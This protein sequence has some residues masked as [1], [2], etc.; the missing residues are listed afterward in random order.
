[1]LDSAQSGQIEIGPQKG[2][3]TTFM[4]SPADIA[5]YGGAAGSGKTMSL[6]LEPIRHI[7]NKGFGA[8]IFRRKSVE[9]AQE[10]GLWDETGNLYPHINGRPR[11][12]PRFEWSFP[13]G[14]KVQ[15]SHLEYEK[16]IYDWQ[17]AQVVMFGFDELTHFC[18]SPDHEVLTQRGWIPI[19]DVMTGDQVFAKVGNSIQLR[20]VLDT[21]SFDYSGDMIE[22][23]QEHGISVKMTPNHRVLVKHETEKTLGFVNADR[24]EKVPQEIFCPS[25]W[26]TMG[27]SSER[28][29][30]VG[31]SD[32][33]KVSYDGKIHCLVVDC[34]L[35]RDF[36]NG[37]WAPGGNFLVRRN[38]RTHFT[39]N[40]ATQFWYMLSRNRSTCGIK[41]YVRATTNPDADSWV[42]ELIAWWINQD[43]GYPIQERSGVLRYFVR[44]GDT[45]IWGDTPEDLQGYKEPDGKPLPVKSL[46]FVSARLEDNEILMRLDPDY[47][48]N[49]MALSTVER[50][51]LL[52]GNWK[53]RPQ[54]GLYFKRQWVENKIMDQAPPM[55]KIVR[56]WDLAA[57]EER[58]GTD[59][60][61]TE[62][63]K[64]GVTY[65]GDFWIL[66]HVFDRLAPGGVEEM[67]LRTARKDGVR[68][69]IAIPQDPAQAGKSQAVNLSKKLAGFDCR[70]K[71]ASGDKITRF[72]PF[73]AQAENGNVYILR[74][75]WNERLIK[76]LENFPPATVGHDDTAD[77]VSEAFDAL[78]RDRNPVVVT[79]YAMH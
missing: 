68:T 60:D 47:R 14:A 25:D 19:A 13:S 1:M 50:E 61:W 79:T 6:L 59:P 78:V 5:I 54:A 9:I 74:A 53:I 44:V 33:Q 12:T 65:S 37:R 8:V 17:G 51:R 63:V 28:T 3:Q 45:L 32:V 34:P 31:P 49:L 21:P 23:D 52:H 35:L 62:G 71:T 15:F 55:S 73:S 58:P 46:T 43:T 42:A 18:L 26:E 10:G 27:D 66:D 2:P 38:G 64:M 67:L 4:A 77:A 48:A 72:S 7:G 69:R 16:N 57:T 56:G 30:R 70:F 22:I 41:P 29:V 39:G 75:P 36:N 20:R 76:Q 24:L 40:S 11:Q